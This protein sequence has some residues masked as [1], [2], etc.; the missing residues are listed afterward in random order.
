LLHLSL[1]ASKADVSLFIFNLPGI[2]IYMLI[3]VDDIIMISSSNM[4]I[5]R[6]LAQLWDDFALKDL[7]TL[8][9]FLGIEVH[10][11][12][13]GLILTQ[14]KYVHDLLDCTNMATCHGVP[15][16][17]LPLDK[18]FLDA[19]DKLS[20][21]DATRYHSVVGALQY[22]SLTH[23]DI[24]F[25]VNKVCQFMSSPTKMHLAGVKWI[26][27]YL[28]DTSATSLCFTHSGSASLSA[29]SDVDWASNV[30]DRRRTS[31]FVIFV[32]GN[33]V[34]S[35]S[36]KQSSVSRSSIESEYMA[37]ANATIELIWIQVL[38][39]ELG[40]SQTR[41]PSLRCDNI[42]ATYLSTNPIFHR[43][44]KHVKVD[45]HFIHEQ[46]T[47][48]Q[49]EVCIIYTKDQLAHALTKPLTGS[50]FSAFRANLKLVSL[51]ID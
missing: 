19:K 2:Q 37:L 44:M 13:Q 42:G 18:L 17:M 6:L 21:D 20:P 30:N 50:A 49:L 26:I 38:L 3:C 33:L 16:P 46:V 48:G 25:A 22:L 9:Y 28:H 23:P 8:N 24:S 39:R 47:T 45:Y 7:G 5:E 36:R 32:G 4:A 41:P 12:D 10:H 11:N 15:T 43:R 40:I 1:K 34:F 14:E 31:S 29:Y 51:C 35:S 27:C